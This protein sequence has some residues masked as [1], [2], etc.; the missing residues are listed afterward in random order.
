MGTE[1]AQSSINKQIKKILEA[2]ETLFWK[3][4]LEIPLAAKKTDQK[5]M[6]GA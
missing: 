3:R 6:R 4:M 5:I 2:V 1:S